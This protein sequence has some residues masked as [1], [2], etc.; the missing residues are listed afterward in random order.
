MAVLVTSALE[1]VTGWLL[2]SI[3]AT[4]WW[5]IPISVSISTVASARQF[6]H[7]RRSRRVGRPF[8]ASGRHESF[9]R[10]P[11]ESQDIIA[12]I[13]AV[14]LAIDLV[15][16]LR[17]LVDFQAKLSSLT[18]FMGIVKD[19]LD[20]REWFNELDLPGSLER[21]RARA[22]S[23]NSELNRKLAASLESITTL[24]REMI[25]LLSAFPQMKSRRHG[26]QSICSATHVRGI[27]G[28]KN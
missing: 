21:L 5:I 4:K 28:W 1:Y 24:P 23:E 2:E 8:S 19:S 26:P 7:F 9:S 25:R 14:I 15:F 13:I 20:V 17:A 18:E 22:S 11:A 16:T 12:A 27:A 3:F 10:V 6:A